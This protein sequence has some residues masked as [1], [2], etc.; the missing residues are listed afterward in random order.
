M[1]E[2]EKGV[3]FF[4]LNKGIFGQR[5]SGSKGV[6]KTVVSGRHDQKHTVWQKE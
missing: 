6:S 5:S 3:L 4:F 1:R 2:T